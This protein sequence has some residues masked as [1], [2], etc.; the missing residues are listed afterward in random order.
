M[1]RHALGWRYGSTGFFRKEL[2]VIQP[3]ETSGCDAVRRQRILDAR[4]SLALLCLEGRKPLDGQLGYWGLPNCHLE[5]SIRLYP[6]QLGAAWMFWML[7]KT[8]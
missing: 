6:F 5:G 1:G 7:Q 2:G 3:I 4:I 8:A